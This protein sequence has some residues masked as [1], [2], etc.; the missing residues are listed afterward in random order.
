MRQ[1]PT[2]GPCHELPC[3][4]MQDCTLASNLKKWVL[5]DVL[6]HAMAS[7]SCLSFVCISRKPP[8]ASACLSFEI[9]PN[10]CQSCKLLWLCAPAATAIAVVQGL[11]CDCAVFLNLCVWVHR[12]SDKSWHQVYTS[13]GRCVLLGG[14]ALCSARGHMGGRTAA[15]GGGLCTTLWLHH[16]PRY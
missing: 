12:S 14:P 5:E 16:H 4:A 6:A 2:S 3:H 10:L 11:T 9:G 13:S 7:L 1:C 15:V 8:T